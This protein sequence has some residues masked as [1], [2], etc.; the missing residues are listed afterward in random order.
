MIK[1]DKSQEPSELAAYRRQHGAT[2]DDIPTEIKNKIRTSLI[3]EQG[4]ICAY[5]NCRIKDNSKTTKIEHVKS[6]S[7]HEDLRLNYRN[8]LL[9][10]KGKLNNR[11]SCDTQKG[12][13]QLSFDPQDEGFLRT[14]QYTSKGDIKSTNPIWNKDLNTILN[15]NASDIIEN[16][17]TAFTTFLQKITRKQWNAHK[18]VYWIDTLRTRNPQGMYIP[19]CGYI[20]YML[21]KRKQR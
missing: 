9:V 19:Y 16:R 11:L 14:I 5:C 8:M 21:E 6:Q 7:E 3:I 20:I 15:L 10:C 17:R 2:Y 18:I 12:D 4:Y 13:K 1:F